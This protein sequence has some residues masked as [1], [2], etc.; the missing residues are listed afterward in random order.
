MSLSDAGETQAEPLDARPSTGGGADDAPS[1]LFSSTTSRGQFH[2]CGSGRRVKLY[3]LED[4][5]WADRGTGF[6]AGVYDEGRD[7]ALLVVRKEEFCESL[8]QVPD[9]PSAPGHEYILVVNESLESDDYLLHA[10]VIKE[11]VYQRQH[12]T[13]VVWTDLEGQDMALSFQEMEGCNEVWDFMTEVQ[14]HYALSHG[15]EFGRAEQEALPEFEL[16]APTPHN[17]AKVEEQ[18]FA[19]TLGGVGMRQKVVEWLLKEEYVRRLVPLFEK[20]EAERDLPLLH[21]LCDVMRMIFTLNDNVLTEYL[22]QEDVF[23]PV[24]GMLEY[25]PEQPKLKASYRAYLRDEAHFHQI[26]DFDDPTIVGKINET[27]RLIYL[28]DVVLVGIMHDA[29]HSMLNSLVFFYQNDIVNY[30]MNSQ[31]VWAQMQKVFASDQGSSDGR[32]TGASPVVQRTKAILFIQ[33]LCAMS[34]QLQLPSRVSLVRALVD[35][36]VL[37][38]LAYALAQPD[39]PLCH[40]ATDILMTMTEYDA[41]CVR[42]RILDQSGAEEHAF[43]PLLHKLAQVLHDTHDAGLRGQ[44]AE[45]WR[46]LMDADA[47]SLAMRPVHDDLDTFLTWLYRGPIQHLFAP[48]YDVPALDALDVDATLPLANEPLHMY[49]HLCDLLCFAMAQHTSRGQGYVLE[50]HALRHVGSLLHARD[51]HMR[52]AA[53]R[54]VRAY[55]SSEDHAMHTHLIESGVLAHVLALLQR[56]APRDNLVSS[57]CLSLLE[58][59]RTDDVHDVLHHLIHAHADALRRLRTNATSSACI[60]ALLAHGERVRAGA[61]APTASPPPPQ[62]PSPPSPRAGAHSDA[63][64]NAHAHGGTDTAPAARR[65][66]GDD[67]ADERAAKRKSLSHDSL[68]HPTGSTPPVPP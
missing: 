7:E 19:G 55:A 18:I 60:T 64:Q 58:Q 3:V 11:D 66:R 59:L 38:M 44:L 31:H 28:K 2:Q 37:D 62:L 49:M 51:K 1:L 26:I 61:H 56:E 45:A 23:F 57:A 13:L 21:A 52:L 39:A 10:P 17:L 43:S 15:L 12:D 9:A 50:T 35:G 42:Q 4:Q 41:A 8:G 48:L 67:D 65:R 63:E 32:D 16:P 54:I 34:R 36:G 22:L 33:Q 29:M 68:R 14:Q 47:D 20:G 46:V 24:V 5:T 27:Y 6:C 53:L 40:A 30:C 25:S